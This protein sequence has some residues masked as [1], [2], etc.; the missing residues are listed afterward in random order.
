MEMIISLF[1]RKHGISDPSGV[2]KNVNPHFTCSNQMRL[3]YSGRSY[4]VDIKEFKPRH[5]VR[6]K[7]FR[8]DDK[9]KPMYESEKRL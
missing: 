8:R 3:F 6:Q 9:W 1:L 2:S 4:N 7:K 5:F